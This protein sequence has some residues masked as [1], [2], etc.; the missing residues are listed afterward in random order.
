MK[1]EEHD[2]K[3]RTSDALLFGGAFAIGLVAMVG[4]FVLG[5]MK[6]CEV[7][8]GPAQERGGEGPT[9]WTK[10]CVLVV[11]AEPVGVVVRDFHLGKWQKFAGNLP[12]NG[13]P[14]RFAFLQLRPMALTLALV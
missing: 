1:D 13:R 5:G 10:S 2:Q 11:A 3:R 12:A 4:C 7:A 14:G 9:G 8:R 6:A